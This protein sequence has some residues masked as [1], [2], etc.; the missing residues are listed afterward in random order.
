MT[1]FE[2]GKS[3][4]EKLKTMHL[5]LQ[6]IFGLAIRMTK[7][8]FGISEGHRPPKRQL[9][10]FE[11]GLTKIDGISKKGKHNYIPSLAGDIYIY[12]PDPKTRKDLIY[13][14]Q[15]LCYVAGVIDAAAEILLEKGEI[16]HRIRWGG[17]WDSDGVLDY[18]QEFDDLPHFE[19]IK[20]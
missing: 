16:S 14:R 18:D 6:K 5:D 10:L 8:D 9:Q 2:F 7:V 13:D 11:K 20:A 19:L 3:S 1:G 4:R 12:H 17:N 15:H